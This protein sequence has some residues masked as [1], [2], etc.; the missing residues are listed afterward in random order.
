[1]VTFLTDLDKSE[2][3]ERLN[4]INATFDIRVHEGYLQCSNDGTTWRNAVS[5]S[6][7]TDT[8][9]IVNAVNSWLVAHPEATTTVQDG[10]ISCEKLDDELKKSIIPPRLCENLLYTRNSKKWVYT[11]TGAANNLQGYYSVSNLKIGHKY[12]VRYKATLSGTNV[13]NILINGVGERCIRIYRE[14]AELDKTY[15]ISMVQVATSET[16]NASWRA[17]YENAED[18]NGS[19]F[20]AEE[21]FLCDITE[22]F[23]EGNEPHTEYMDAILEHSNIDY[24]SQYV[25]IITGGI[26]NSSVARHLM[27]A[28]ESQYGNSSQGYPYVKTNDIGNVEISS[29]PKFDW[30]NWSLPQYSYG[31]TKKIDTPIYNYVHG[32]LETDAMFSVQALYGRWTKNVVPEVS[33]GH[34]YGGHVFEAWNAPR[35]YRYTVLIGKNSETESCVFT[36]SPLTGGGGGNFGTV[37]FGSDITGEGLLVGQRFAEMGG[38]FTIN[39]KLNVQRRTIS[40]STAT[41]TAGEICFDTNYVYFCVADN[42]WKRISLETW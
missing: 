16:K 33:G 11:G 27:G 21:I 32:V 5:V 31:M 22:L 20:T 40:S 18:S 25:N 29:A 24:T 15:T 38:D 13:A 41:G 8:D 36:F 12:Y 39:G 7:L 30:E 26:I 34:P 35:T 42:T 37:R 1:M 28:Q 2:I 14:N 3:L 4:N 19:T 9:T 6:E 23:G 10:S 17:D